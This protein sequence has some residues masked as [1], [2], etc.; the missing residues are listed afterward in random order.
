MALFDRASESGSGRWH[1]RIEHPTG[2]VSFID[3][4]ANSME[5]AVTAAQADYP[6]YTIVW[7][8]REP[9]KYGVWRRPLVD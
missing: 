4:H 2:I 8:V 1:V 3:I 5:D 7:A 6:G 9:D